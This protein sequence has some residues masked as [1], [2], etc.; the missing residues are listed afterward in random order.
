MYCMNCGKPLKDGARFCTAC[1]APVQPVGTQQTEVQKNAV[2]PTHHGGTA[3]YDM[4]G[5]HTPLPQK[6]GK[7]KKQSNVTLIVA[8][9]ALAVATAVVVG[10]VLGGALGGRKT[11]SLSNGGKPSTTR[12]DTDKTRDP[13]DK[14]DT[15]GASIQTMKRPHMLSFPAMGTDVTPSVTPYQ[16]ASD[17][18]DLINFQQFEYDL[19]DDACRL[20]AQN[21]FVVVNMP[22]AR[23]FYEVY[24]GNRYMQVPNFVT[25]DS[26]MHTYHLYFSMLLSQTEKDYLAA[27]LAALSR[28][29]LEQ[30]TLQYEALT[31][32]KWESAA[33]RNVAFFAVGAL[34][35][36][37]TTA[38]PDAVRETVSREVER[39]YD[40]EGIQTC[41]LTDEFMDYSQY[42][43]RGNYVG[44]ETLERYF[45][46]MM[47]YGQFNYAQKDEDMSRSALLMTLAMQADGFDAWEHIYMVTS[48]F[49]GASDDLTYYEYLPAI[50]SAYGAIPEASSLPE[51]ENA[52]KRF[53]SLIE[54]LEP[55]K[56]NSVV[57][58][59][60][61]GTADLPAL[62][63]GFRF[64]GQRFTVDA[65]VMQQL[66]YNSVKENSAGQARMLPDTLDLPA[67]LGSDTALDILT[68][69]GE[70]D[71]EGYSEKMQQL[72][73]ELADA[74]DSLWTAS[75]SASWLY[76]LEPLLT[77]KGAGW[78][79]FMTTREWSKKSLETYAGSYAE[80]KH[81]TVLYAKQV[82]A[83]MGGGWEEWDDRGYVEPEYEVYA[84]FMEL[85]QQTADGLDRFGY[86]GDRDREELL[87][88]AELARQLMTIS[89]KELRGETLTDD[90]YDTIRYYGGTL[91]HFWVEA[92]QRWAGD[93]T[94]SVLDTPSGIVVD[95]ATD[96]NGT[97]LEIAN[98][99]PSK[100]IVV[101]Q[102]DGKLRLASGSVY[103]FYQ[104]EQPIGD[105]LTDQQWQQM[106][107]QKPQGDGTYQ[108][109]LNKQKPD[110]T[111]SYR[112]D[113]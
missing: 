68:M 97:V 45:R 55:P 93:N 84:R 11:P 78:P 81:D 27:E 71:Y 10:L 25:V 28:K 5:V 113:G 31:G 8:L 67:A 36:D 18:S 32:T 29:M 40:A 52:F 63:K 44:D 107:G 102:I 42:K 72:R 22:Y 91:E 50:E 89:K 109:T 110:W 15:D 54:K 83:E 26:L 61:E 77:E 13:D 59:D 74:P 48:C 73:E 16:V 2:P 86:I 12:G 94:I 64:M 35:Q 37:D 47:W 33:E 65:A 95:I 53:V 79:S 62:G 112:S 105:R 30:S 100:I 66:V 60:P 87:R 58:V 98:A 57:V 104:F 34:L 9:L 101:V 19:T 70:T 39:I 103:N 24:E 92:A 82:M 3:Q 23:E 99:Q 80:L 43:P 88:L 17:L 7:P 76:T 21:Q 108:S 51:N 46:A 106:I 20:L 4:G 111:T 49:A 90:E 14:P 96:P 75:L 69:Q 56:I 85:A 6:P 1:G 38:V 41:T